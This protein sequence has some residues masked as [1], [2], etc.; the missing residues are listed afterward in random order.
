MYANGFVKVAALSP[1]LHTAD[2][3]FNVKEIHKCLKEVQNKKVDIALFPEMCIC[4]Y[5]IGDLVFQEYLYQDSLNA[6]SYLLKNNPYDGVVIVGS[7]FK[8]K[9]SIFNCACVIQK[10][11]ILGIVPKSYL[12][13]TNEFYETRWFVSG[14][15]FLDVK[16]IS[17]NGKMVPFGK[18]IFTNKDGLVKFG[19]EICEDMWAP[20]PP[21]EE[22]YAN[23]AILVLNASASPEVIGKAEK[24]RMMVES[25][26]YRCNGAYVYTSNNPSESSS[27]VIFSNHKI[28]MEN[29]ELVAESHNINY[30]D[31]QILYGDFDVLKLHHARKTNGWV[32]NILHHNYYHD[33]QEIAYE[34]KEEKEFVFEKELDKMPFVPK[35]EEAYKN[36]IDT[37][38]TSVMKR[39]E[40]IGIK[41]TI[42]GVSGGLDST[43]ALLS[44]CHMCDMYGLNRKNIVAV[45]MPSSNNSDTT[46]QNA[47]KMMKALKVD[48]REINIKEQVINELATIG[49]DTVTKDVTY[50]NAQ[51]RYRTFT[52]MNLANKEKGIV[53]GTSDM[54]EVALGWSTFNGDQM[55][56]YGINSGIPKTVIKETVRYYKNIYPFLSD[57]LDSVINTPISPELAGSNQLTE[58]IIGKYEINDFILYHFL[59]CGDSNER[60]VYFLKRFFKMEENNA[61]DYVN[62][63]YNRFFHQQYKRLTMPEGVKI[64]DLSLS[65]RTQTRLSGDIYNT[66][67]EKKM[68]K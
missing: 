10:D 4:G 63:F 1:I 2:C 3:M 20:M 55:A 33:Y 64:L 9:D 39:L 42:L 24:R 16:E 47:L 13:H 54:S 27:E 62:N 51:A 14:L 46:Y 17:V 22:L 59:V 36:I 57:V 56:M 19:V 43:L 67:L 11:K 21:H 5:S 35:E 60:I 48:M 15:E 6:I 41:K 34:L 23:G 68:K 66:P 28:M 12:P 44:L 49:H 58:D 40:Y 61:I 65:P 53:I 18:L 52:L 32:K 25:A 38:A 8:I 26:S 45:T 29:G 30:N 37:Q 7:F 50:E 31:S